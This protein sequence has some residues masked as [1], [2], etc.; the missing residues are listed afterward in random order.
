MET[1]AYLH[2]LAEQGKSDAQF[3]IGYRLAF[4]RKNPRPRRWEEVL[5]WWQPAADQGVRRAQLYLG[6]CYRAW[7]RS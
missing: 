6:V 7:A 4:G 3:R 5:R 1:T 2:K